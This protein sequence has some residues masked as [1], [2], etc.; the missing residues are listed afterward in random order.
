MCVAVRWIRS[1]DVGR[2]HELDR[3]ECMTH[4]FRSIGWMFIPTPPC[5]IYSADEVCRPLR[6]W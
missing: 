6:F 5:E 1:D 3:D 2:E 4:L